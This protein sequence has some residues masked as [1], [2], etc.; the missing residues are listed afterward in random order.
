MAE[1]D[2]IINVA[3]GDGT[4]QEMDRLLKRYKGTRDAGRCIWIL[5]RPQDTIIRFCNILNDYNK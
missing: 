2:T 3:F 1:K 5:P 4:Y